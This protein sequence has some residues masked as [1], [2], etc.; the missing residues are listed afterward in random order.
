M[1][2]APPPTVHFF[3]WG[4]VIAAGCLSD[5]LLTHNGFFF[6]LLDFL[7]ICLYHLQI[8]GIKI[9]RLINKKNNVVKTVK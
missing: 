7:H 6:P 4:V 1:L 9:T 8:K 3:S 5:V 2:E